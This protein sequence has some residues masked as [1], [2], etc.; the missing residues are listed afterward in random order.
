M[1]FHVTNV[2]HN[3]E[4]YNICFFLKSNA[5]T[6]QGNNCLF[7]PWIVNA[8][9]P[10]LA[11]ET[12]ECNV[13]YHVFGDKQRYESVWHLFK[14]FEAAKYIDGSSF[15]SFTSSPESLSKMDRLKGEV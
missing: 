5:A 13:H 1:L 6:I 4:Q 11:L 8:F 10:E 3:N 12:K 9:L 7:K 2:G 15:F 14:T